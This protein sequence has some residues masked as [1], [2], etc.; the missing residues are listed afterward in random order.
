MA[1][2]DIVCG[3]CE[4]PIH[5]HKGTKTGYEHYPHEDQCNS[6]PPKPGEKK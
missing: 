2:G 1:K 6:K 5:E 3:E 4:Q